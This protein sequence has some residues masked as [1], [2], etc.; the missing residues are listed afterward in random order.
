M[1]I[2]LLSGICF[3]GV[4]RE[5]FTSLLD[6]YSNHCPWGLKFAFC[7]FKLAYPS[8]DGGK[9]TCNGTWSYRIVTFDRLIP[10]P[11]TALSTENSYY[12]CK[13][14]SHWVPYIFV[15]LSPFHFFPSFL[16]LFPS[17]KE[18]TRFMRWLHPVHDYTLYRHPVNLELIDKC[19]Q[20]LAW[21]LRI[22]L[23]TAPT[24]KLRVLVTSNN[25]MTAARKFSLWFQLYTHRWNFRS[26]WMLCSV[27][28]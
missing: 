17:S 19:S 6:Q 12:I 25:D 28:W 14:H 24:S 27:G 1:D 2:Y 18:N 15:S 8:Y 21:T 4:H 22:S 11:F 10:F 7:I 13:L 26:S 20:N 9:C 16:L 5:K 3:Y 23:Q